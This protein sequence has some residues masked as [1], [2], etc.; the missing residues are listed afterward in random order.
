MKWDYL[1]V[2]IAVAEAGSTLGA[3]KS[4]G[5]NQTTVSRRID[6]LEKTAGL[7]LFTREPAGYRL[8]ASGRELLKVSKPVIPVF[9]NITTT[10]EDLAR[11]DTMH[12]RLSGPAEVINHWI[13]PILNRFRQRHSGV[14]L[15]VDTN[16]STV[17]LHA[18]ESDLAVR[19][20]DEIEDE[21][22]IARRIATVPW[23]VYCSR[24]YETRQ[25]K[26]RD[27]T[28]AS[29]HNFV[30]YTH[31]VACR[32]QPIR[33]VGE[34]LDD[35]RITLRV[36]SVPGMVTALKSEDAI[37]VLPKVV[38]DHTPELVPCFRHDEMRHNCWGVASPEA[39]RRPLV[40]ACMR[41]I[42]EEF[43]GDTL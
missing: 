40:R 12:L 14:I 43:P 21:R 28:E 25:G 6:A 13:Y 3:S 2:F 17:D 5:L 18:G 32:I 42:A 7:V 35:T 36:S 8:T 29:G 26:P 37:G 38:G 24:A 33:W 10:I 1:K 39:H 41:Q 9:Q 31:R 16:E 19:L 22:L 30:H 34:H 15:E 23:A 20:T 11:H 27:I 4:L